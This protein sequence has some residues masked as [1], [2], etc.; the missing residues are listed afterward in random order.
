MQASFPTDRIIN[1]RPGSSPELAQA[2]QRRARRVVSC[3]PGL[4]FT[5]SCCGTLEFV[6]RH[7]LDYFD[8]S[9]EELRAWPTSDAL[10]PDDRTRIAVESARGIQSG[11]TYE[12]EQRLR[13]AD[14]VYRWFHFRA[15]PVRGANGSILRWYGLL[16]DIDEMK[17]AQDSLQ[18]SEQGLRMLVDSIPG[19]VYTRTP[20]GEIESV[21]RQ[22]LA[23][24]G[25]SLDDVRAWQMRDLVHP[26]ELAPTIEEWRRKLDAGEPYETEH[27][28]RRADG[29][30]RW[31]RFRV[32]PRRDADGRLLRWYGLL[33]DVDDLRRAEQELR[34]TH[35]RLSRATQLATVSELAASI[36]HEINQPL[37]AVV[38]H[39][40]ACHRWLAAHPVNTDRARL[41]AECVVRDGNVAAEVVR[42]IRAL[43]RHAPPIKE[44][45]DLNHAIEQVL[46][47]MMDDLRKQGIV[48]QTALQH[49]LAS[50]PADR[51]QIQQ[52]LA[53][54]IR[55]A[56]EA[57]DGV[58]LRPKLLQITTRQQ[59]G[60]ACVQVKDH[61]GGIDAMSPLFDPFHTTKPTGMGVG[62]AICRSIVEAHGGRITAERAL[63]HGAT[64]SF[65]LRTMEGDT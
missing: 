4:V 65:T 45:I 22:M 11:R 26:D 9:I 13:R 36:A 3:V 55:N 56:I 8:K 14:G 20:S 48:L 40:E 35:A 15:A 58:T 41:S 38:A 44:W 63:P 51:V 50:V 49:D 6:N 17:R 30:Y 39:G 57:M 2:G 19:M 52:V 24:F 62:L 47:L 7:L 34:N 10:H 18:A 25:K 32:T 23:Y 21:N 53:N 60:M 64:F 28:L 46:G 37:A 61:G 43:F 1:D 33:T 54:L 27:R 31:F 42:R 12:L 5:M 29:V 59:G 16:T